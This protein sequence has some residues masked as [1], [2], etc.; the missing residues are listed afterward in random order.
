MPVHGLQSADNI[1]AKVF[2]DLKPDREDFVVDAYEWIG[3]ALGLIGAAPQYIDDAQIVEIANY[4]GLLPCG[5][6]SIEQVG[7]KPT[8]DKT[9]DK[10]KNVYDD[11]VPMI[12]SSGTTHDVNTNESGKEQAAYNINGNYIRTPFESGEVMVFFRGMP[13]DDNGYPKV[14]ASASYSQALYWYIVLKLIE[15]GF[16]HP[17]GIGLPHAEQ[18][19]KKYCAQSFTEA[20]YPSIDGYESFRRQWTDMIQSLNQHDTFF[21]DLSQR[22]YDIGPGDYGQFGN[23]GIIKSPI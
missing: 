10:S 18:R 8:K 3:E 22:G 14:P 4:R 21:N 11:L 13:V 23:Q 6:M 20:V 16:R 17:A 12:E 1:I 5:A 7:Y 19:W 2:R 15:G 9:F